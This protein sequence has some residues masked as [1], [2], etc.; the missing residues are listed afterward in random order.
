[1]IIK[2]DKLDKL[3]ENKWLEET[4][5]VKNNGKKLKSKVKICKFIECFFV[6]AKN[7]L[8]A[9]TLVSKFLNYKNILFCC[10]S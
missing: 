2:F 7:W 3:R 4:K 10:T 1:M 8:S 9:F 5:Q 6:A